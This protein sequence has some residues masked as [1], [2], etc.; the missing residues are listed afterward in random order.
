M[1]IRNKLRSITV[2]SKKV[3]NSI[4]LEYEGE[5][6]EF[7]QITYRDR[8]SLLEKSEGKDGKVDGTAFQIWGVISMTYVPGTEEKVF[9]EGDFDILMNQP[10]G[11]FIDKF[12][13]EITK[14]LGVSEEAEKN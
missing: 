3:V 12:S 8:K 9:D 13:E 1:S 11:G 2:G 4:E 5:K 14:L 7:R 10:V 6:F